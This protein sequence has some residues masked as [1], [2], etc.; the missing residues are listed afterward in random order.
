MGGNFGP[1]T[2]VL[3]ARRHPFFTRLGDDLLA[4]VTIP[5][6][7]A[8]M[9]AC[10]RIQTLDERTI[11]LR[12]PEGKVARPGSVWCAAGEGMP[13][14]KNVTERGRLLVKFSVEFPPEARATLS[15]VY[16][17]VYIPRNCGGSCNATHLGP[18]HSA[19]GRGEGRPQ[20]TRRELEQGG[21]R[22]PGLRTDGTRRRSSKWSWT[23]NQSEA[24]H[25]RIVRKATTS[26]AET[27]RWPAV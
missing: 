27:V 5:L 11:Q 8:L 1:L 6:Y 2:I 10:V 3:R 19:V 17:P 21:S 9:R 18:C 20:G 12:L 25:W 14:W 15:Q 26:E 7:Q 22:R 23:V 16:L 13:K 4:H 24:R